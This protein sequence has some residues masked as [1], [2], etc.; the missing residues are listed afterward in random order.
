MT[1]VVLTYRRPDDLAELLPMLLEQAAGEDVVV[2]VLVVDN[3]P[4]GSARA[5]VE[6]VGAPS[7]YV[8]EPRPGISAAR[9]RALDEVGHDGLLVFIDDDE[10]PTPGWLHQMLGLH[11]RTAAVAVVGPVVSALPSPL[12][13]WVEAGRFFDRRRLPTGTAIDVAATNNLLVDLRA[14][15]A[16]GLR[17]DEAFGLSGGSD[18]LFTRRLAA[19]GAPMLWCDEAVVTDVVPRD[20]ATRSWVLHRARRSGNS[21]SRVSVLLADGRVRRAG[22]RARCVAEGGV[23]VAAGSARAVAGRV[24]RDTGHEARGRR[25]AERGL[26]MIGGA[27]GR[28]VYDYGRA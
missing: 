20:R 19:T 27:V 1:V 24:L 18:T 28:V 17:F 25:T 10:R 14:V 6:A 16:A 3:D 23:R 15:A 26:G 12:D 7:R 8:H 22:V 9:N 13:P 5:F 2:D 4:E 11:R 21:G